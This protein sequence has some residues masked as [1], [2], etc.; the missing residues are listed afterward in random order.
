MSKF[1]VDLTKIDETTSNIAD[2]FAKLK[3]D[4]LLDFKTIANHNIEEKIQ[5]IKDFKQN[6]LA[7]IIQ[8][9]SQLKKEKDECLKDGE[10]SNKKLYDEYG[11]L[12]YPPPFNYS[13]V[14]ITYG[15][16]KKFAEIR[17]LG[18]AFGI[19]VRYYLKDVPNAGANIIE[20][21][22]LR[23][24]QYSQEFENFSIFDQVAE[25]LAS[26][27]NKFD[28]LCKEV[29]QPPPPQKKDW[30]T[31]FRKYLYPEPVFKSTEGEE[32]VD[33][34]IENLKI[35]ET[36][37]KKY[38]VSGKEL[39]QEKDRLRN[40]KIDIQ[41]K[42]NTLTTKKKQEADPVF[43]SPAKNTSQ[44][45]SKSSP[46]NKCSQDQINNGLNYS[47]QFKKDLELTKGKLSA[48]IRK[49]NPKCLVKETI[50]CT[51]PANFDPCQ[52]LFKDPDPINFYK[53]LALL[54]SAGFNSI[55]DQIIVSIE[56][57]F[58][59]TELR[60]KRKEIKQLEKL[61]A[62]EE[63][64]L[65]FYKSKQENLQ[66]DIA[67]VLEELAILQREI[68]LLNLA[69][70][71]NSSRNINIRIAD[72]ESEKQ[73]ILRQL[74]TLNNDISVL[75][76]SIS[77]L[78]SNLN[79]NKTNKQ[80]IEEEYGQ[81]IKELN[82]NERQGELIVQGKNLEA[83][84]SEPN[85]NEQMSS[86]AV[87]TR[88]INV[89]DGIVPF[90]NLCA[91][92]Y[93]ALIGG[94]N[95]Q[96]PEGFFDL[97][98]I[99]VKDPFS[100]FYATINSSLLSMLVTALLAAI[101][102]LL[103][104]LCNSLDKA[105]TEA[106][107]GQYARLLQNTSDTL[108]DEAGQFFSRI[109]LSNVL[110]L[111]N[112]NTSISF[113]LENF[114]VNT[115]QDKRFDV[116]IVPVID[117]NSNVDALS[118]WFPGASP[119]AQWDI[120]ADR[121]TFIYKPISGFFDINQITQFVQTRF[122]NSLGIDLVNGKF[123]ARALMES[124]ANT[125]AEADFQVSPPSTIQQSLEEDILLSEMKCTIDTSAS[126]M[127]PTQT[128]E[129]LTKNPSPETRRLFI[130]IAEHCAPISLENYGLD[131]VMNFLGE[132]GIASGAVE[133]KKK[134]E[135][136]IE[137]DRRPDSI[138]NISC[139]DF[140]TTENFILSL[141]QKT[142]S[143]ELAKQIFD[144]IQEKR[145]D[146]FNFLLDSI[147]GLS[148]GE[149]PGRKNS[150]SQTYYNIIN[151]ILSAEGAPIQDIS[152]LDLEEQVENS[153]ISNT[154][155]NTIKH[156]TDS[157]VVLNS[158]F[159]KTVDSLFRPIKNS[160][161]NDIDGYIRTISGNKQVKKKIEKKKSIGEQSVIDPMFMLNVSSDMYPAIKIPPG[162]K[163]LIHPPSEKQK[164]QDEK[165]KKQ[166][167]Y[168]DLIAAG[169]PSYILLNDDNKRVDDVW[170]NGTT[171]YGEVAVIQK[172][173]KLNYNDFNDRSKAN[174]YDWDDPGTRYSQM[175]TVKISG[176]AKDQGFDV[177]TIKG[178]R[179]LE[180]IRAAVGGREFNE[181]QINLL[182]TFLE[183][184][185]GPVYAEIQHRVFEN[186][187][188]FPSIKKPYS[189]SRKQGPGTAAINQEDKVIQ[190]WYEEI[191]DQLDYIKDTI[192][193]QREQYRN[194]I[195]TLPVDISKLQQDIENFKLFKVVES[196]ED[197]IQTVMLPSFIM[198]FKK[199]MYSDEVF[200]TVPFPLEPFYFN[201]EDIEKEM[202]VTGGSLTYITNGFRNSNF[203]PSFIEDDIFEDTTE[204]VVGQKFI[205]S[206]EEIS[207]NLQVDASTENISIT[208]EMRHN[209]NN[210]NSIEKM[211]Q[212]IGQ[213]T[214]NL[215]SIISEPIDFLCLME[216]VLENSENIPG[217]I[218]D[219]PFSKN[220]LTKMREAIPRWRFSLFEKILPNEKIETE[221][222]L[223]ST[224]LSFI[225]NEKYVDFYHNTSMKI[226]DKDISSDI[227]AALVKK[228]G[229]IL[230]KKESFFRVAN[231]FIDRDL[232]IYK[233]NLDPGRR[234]MVL[235]RPTT[236]L[237]FVPQDF[238]PTSIFEKAIETAINFQLQSFIDNRL[239]KETEIKNPSA[240]S[241]NNQS[242]Q[243]KLKLIQTANFTRE[244]TKYEKEN[245][246]DPS[247]VG[248]ETLKEQFK[249]LYKS[250]TEEQLTEQQL[251]GES[252][253]ENKM[254]KS[255]KNIMLISFVKICIAEHILKSIFIY[256]NLNFSNQCSKFEFVIKDLAKYIV[257]ES[258]RMDFNLD[259]Q[260]QS[261]L[262]YSIMEK[263]GKIEKIQDIEERYD[264]WS[265]NNS[266]NSLEPNP[267]LLEIIRAI[268]KEVIQKFNKLSGCNNEQKEESNVLDYLFNQMSIINVAGFIESIGAPFRTYSTIDK[269]TVEYGL[270]GEDTIRTLYIE[271]YIK[272]GTI[273][274]SKISLEQNAVTTYRTWKWEELSNAVMSL[275]EFLEILKK[276]TETNI[277][278]KF[279]PCSSNSFYKTNH[280]FG[281]RI[282]KQISVKPYEDTGEFR[283]LDDYVLTKKDLLRTRAY[284]DIVEY[285]A[286]R[287]TIIISEEEIDINNEHIKDF[288]KLQETYDL[289]YHKNLF[290]SLKTNDN[291][292]IIFNYSFALQD[293]TEFMIINS[294]LIHNDQLGRF[295]FE[296]SKRMIKKMWY[297]N[298]NLGNASVSVDAFNDMLEQQQKNEQNTGNP[299]GPSLEALKFFY[300]TPIQILKGVAVQTDPNV[301]LADKVVAGAA[302]AGSLIGQR[303]DIPYFLASLALLPAPLFNGVTPPIPPLTAYNIAFPAGI[304][305]LVSEIILRSLPYYKFGNNGEN[306]EI[307][308]DSATGS[309][310]TK[311]AFSCELIKEKNE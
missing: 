63:E 91:L 57:E 125:P 301:A 273:D 176:T 84:F 256:D 192:E 20:P 150:A 253:S 288:T 233:I 300:R 200:S 302:M 118:F 278:D 116:P 65:D 142:V 304:I 275:P 267:K 88:I 167:E 160:Y 295:L 266:L 121:K 291:T 224:G 111:G 199:N 108:G 294:N 11:N 243:N 115:Q 154:V 37:G 27:K 109:N 197:P 283:F 272:L 134:I 204:E 55:Y 183:H 269:E 155:Q 158:M 225:P 292:K 189:A 129:I 4:M 252:S 231:S 120:S 179:N 201:D 310:E 205:E 97:K 207:K 70:Q 180:E 127:T 305:F 122:A 148:D 80:Q 24:L 303:I 235:S 35:Q 93:Q 221:I 46:K 285:G 64:L 166:K 298:R 31:E 241:V 79:R 260:K 265:E 159:E 81:K 136:F 98:D 240:I 33:L 202:I 287:N 90:E 71:T 119:A 284:Y 308:S 66:A 123:S 54:K 26:P 210:K 271:K 255:A 219:L 74:E 128:L 293:F 25:T 195:A 208:L 162:T 227:S 61:I 82:Y 161:N 168:D 211:L 138:E 6:L 242:Q 237:S 232:D 274:S 94:I 95:F 34:F 203:S 5:N 72:K 114:D 174:S 307:T 1:V 218:Q 185:Y 163:I 277:L 188:I 244:P 21:T 157:N 73:K 85:E 182:N 299:F 59:I 177:Q 69:S 12:F 264:S 140:D 141:L 249:E 106:F 143:P 247:I 258:K 87:Y 51:L 184:E 194:S 60:Q 89:I 220:N 286:E 9:N 3:D 96:I 39:E 30:K 101:D 169:P 149:I 193:Q 110:T 190:R 228:S 77:T 28:K 105:T 262:T 13:F 239:L 76:N 223:E 279:D 124:V 107:S 32:A 181:Q 151:Q 49:F 173:I 226:S 212:T 145:I 156:L 246:L 53:K 38:Y 263:S 216:K 306:T 112:E 68:D 186:S 2:H 234:N 137:S 257:Q 229:K 29:T 92:I 170:L 67:S 130:A 62:E 222:K 268:F 40:S 196:G 214:D 230:T 56:D 7:L 58:G 52:I 103:S 113:G 22:T 132:L 296:S 289:E 133:L 144:K 117:L 135:N 171:E 281:L 126:L 47:E 147:V 139:E 36:L 152:E 282:M 153:N 102:S 309:I 23:V 78:S 261:K 16:Y 75:P 17:L 44:D 245:N 48:W 45:S 254:T 187:G 215:N 175:L 164:I 146:D 178:Y 18:D 250:E 41:K 42:L 311:P 270:I 206:M 10:S 290:N 280:K 217:V 19:P 86:L 259:L 104:G 238:L 99:Q 209:G 15:S 236:P 251:R 191:Q 14:E 8:K 297:A 100:G 43:M 172:L 276:A 131:Y 213:S 50:D 198:P 83:V 248:F 165:N